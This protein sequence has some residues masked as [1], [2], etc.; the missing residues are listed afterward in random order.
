MFTLEA[1]AE[2][3]S[4]ES[5]GIQWSMYYRAIKP[6]K[7]PPTDDMRDSKKCPLFVAQAILDKSN[8]YSM[9]DLEK[10]IAQQRAFQNY[11]KSKYPVKKGN[12]YGK[13]QNT[14]PVVKEETA[15]AAE[16]D[17]VMQQAA[18]DM[19]SE[20][21][22]GKAAEEAA[23]QDEAKPQVD[24]A[25][26][27]KIANDVASYIVAKELARIKADYEAKIA[28]MQLPTR[29]ELVERVKEEV[30]TKDMGIQ[31][32]MFPDLLQACQAYKESDGHSL[33]IM[34]V[35][36]AGSGKTTAAKM[37]ARALGRK[38]Y[39]NG[40]IDSEYKLLGFTDAQGRI[41]H[42][43]FRDAYLN[44][45]VYLF[46]ELDASLPPAVLAF[47]AATANGMCDF[48][49]GCFERHE[50]NVI[51]A[52]CNTFGQGATAQ[53]VGRMK[54]DGAFLDRFAVIEWGI[55]EKLEMHLTSNKDW[56]AMVQRIRANAKRIG[57]DQIIISP[58]AT[59]HGAAL[60]KQG[61][62]IDKVLKMTV[63]KG[64]PDDTWNR[65]KV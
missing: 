23:K 39:F 11:N 41:V 44:P 20:D 8:C 24:T 29:V 26:I 37:V 4:K 17:E 16:D 12:K 25:L 65:I 27:T 1:I 48:P 40:A 42:R 6:N 56:C 28:A 14:I 34:I 19:A 57:Q 30:V 60:L 35:G 51:L 22:A 31:H 55:D 45:S 53:Y 43:P 2:R 33:C 5:I 50:K 47:N 9:D 32:Y 54:Q 59:E 49:D 13:E 3:L 15:K 52:A 61:F 21:A 10:W 64:I 62:S 46:D 18:D 63:K 7:H 58:R 38:Y 36:P